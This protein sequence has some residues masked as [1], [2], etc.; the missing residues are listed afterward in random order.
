VE[1]RSDITV[2]WSSNSFKSQAVP[3]VRQKN[4]HIWICFL[5][6][7]RYVLHWFNYKTTN[8]VSFST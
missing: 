2:M 7:L 3:S 1:S 5:E 4:T 6:E 8:N